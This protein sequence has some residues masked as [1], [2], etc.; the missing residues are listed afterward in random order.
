M[1]LPLHTIPYFDCN[2]QPQTLELHLHLVITDSQKKKN[3]QEIVKEVSLSINQ[4]TLVGD[5]IVCNHQ[6]H[7]LI[8]GQG[9]GR[10]NTPPWSSKVQQSY[11][12]ETTRQ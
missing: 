2:S 9:S 3:C 1:H 10:K 8:K 6:E 11:P 12:V 5:Y 4:Q 7:L